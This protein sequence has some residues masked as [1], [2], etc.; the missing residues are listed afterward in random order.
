MFECTFAQLRWEPWGHPQKGNLVQLLTIVFVA[1]KCTFF[2]W[3]DVFVFVFC[4]RRPVLMNVMLFWW[5]FKCYNIYCIVIF[6]VITWKINF[7]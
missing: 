3:L 1:L 7:D 2:M 6:S 5:P 4:F